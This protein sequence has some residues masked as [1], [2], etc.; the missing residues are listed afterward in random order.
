MCKEQTQ[1]LM[2]YKCIHYMIARLKLQ[3]TAKSLSTLVDKR[4]CPRF[5]KTI[6]AELNRLILHP[7]S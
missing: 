4:P 6:T 7:L 1:H 5:T 2:C 3:Q